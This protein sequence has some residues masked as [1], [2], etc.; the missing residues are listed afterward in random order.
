MNLSTGDISLIISIF[1]VSNRFYNYVISTISQLIEIQ[2]KSQDS[3]FTNTSKP[4][5]TYNNIPLFTNP[6]QSSGPTGSR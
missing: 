4:P 1:Y 3:L 6:N 2:R 5:I